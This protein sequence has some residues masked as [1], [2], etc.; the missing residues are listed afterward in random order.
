LVK[1]LRVGITE[2]EWHQLQPLLTHHGE[3]SF[4]LRKAIRDF[5]STGGGKDARSGRGQRERT[6]KIS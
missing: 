1:V 5:I 4:I 2:E 6:S 3:L